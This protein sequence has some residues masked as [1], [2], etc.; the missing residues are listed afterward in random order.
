MKLVIYRD[1]QSKEI[2]SF[3]GFTKTCTDEALKNY[4]SNEK[5]ELCAE[6]VEIEENSLC[7]Y[8]YNLKV[9]EKEDYYSRL[10]DLEDDIGSLESHIRC[11]LDNLRELCE[12]E[13]K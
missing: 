3:H 7:Y 13:E 2:K 10:R 11:E 6:I 1:K 9:I 4:N 8:F 5:N 12:T